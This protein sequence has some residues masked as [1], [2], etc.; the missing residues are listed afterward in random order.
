MTQTPDITDDRCDS[1]S[2][3]TGRQCTLRAAIEES[4][5]T[6]GADIIDFD[7]GGTGAQAIS[8]TSELPTITDTL[9]IDGYTQAGASENTLE[10]GNDAVLNVA[11]GGLS[12]G[13]GADGLEIAAPDCT[14]KGLVIRNFEGS[15]ILITGSGATGNR[16]EGNFIGVNRDGITDKGNL[17]GVYIDG[18]SNT[19]GG[20]QPEVRNVIS[21]N[22]GDGVLMFG[23]GATD[24]R[25]EG[26]V[27]GTTANGTAA[28]G[29]TESGVDISGDASN[30]TVGGT[31][32][33]A[34]NRIARN[35]EDGVQVLG[36]NASNRILSKRIYRTRDW[37]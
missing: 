20:T 22:D 35:G 15:G 36:P 27:L 17:A 19:V 29:N 11:L 30:N 6:A 26:N 7:L 12:A 9:T 21:G 37:A 23:T 18:T 5:D 4:N 25:V 32:P 2:A 24:N 1:D 3:A 8:P 28:L 16:I 10:E 33:G 31:L 14:I 13:A 34:V